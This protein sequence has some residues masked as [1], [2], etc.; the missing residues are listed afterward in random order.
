[1][2]V[3]IYTCSFSWLTSQTF[4]HSEHRVICLESLKMY[5]STGHNISADFVKGGKRIFFFKFRAKNG[6]LR[7]SDTFSKTPE[8]DSGFLTG[9]NAQTTRADTELL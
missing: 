2:S 5:R 6:F 1:M 3:T 7:V 8:I 4:A 9:K